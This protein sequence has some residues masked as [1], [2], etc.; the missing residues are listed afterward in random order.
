MLVA[1]PQPPKINAGTTPSQHTS[2]SS[3]WCGLMTSSSLAT[4]FGAVRGAIGPMSVANSKSSAKSGAQSSPSA[5]L[6]TTPVTL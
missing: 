1:C 4:T 5:L 3:E 6:S 2:V